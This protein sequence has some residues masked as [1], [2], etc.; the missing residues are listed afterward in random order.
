M[1]KIG[2]GY[3]SSSALNTDFEIIEEG[4]ERTLDRF[5]GPGNQMESELDMNSHRI[6]NLPAPQLPGDPVRVEDITDELIS[7]LGP[8]VLSQKANTD[9]GNISDPV[10]REKLL[11][12]D[13]VSPVWYGARG[14][15]I[16]ND[17]AP[18]QALE[19]LYSGR[20]VDLGGRTYLV[21]N[22][23]IGNTYVNGNFLISENNSRPDDRG[24]LLPSDDSPGMISGLTTTGG[25]GAPYSGGAN[26]T[27]TVPGRSTRNRRGILLSQ[28]SRADFNISGCF[29]SIYSWA[30]GN[31]SA[32]VAA[33]Q[34][35]AGAPQA[36]N[37]GS[38]EAQGYGFG[39]TNLCTAFSIA[40]GSRVGNLVTRNGRAAGT[41]SGNLFTESCQV[42][43]GK[44]ARLGNDSTGY[45]TVVG[46]VITDIPIAVAGSGYDPLVDTISIVDRSS[47]GSGASVSSFTV[48]G[49]G[50]ITGIAFTGGSGY[51]QNT[52]A[53]VVSP[54]ATSG[55][56][57]GTSNT[58]S[59]SA[60][61][62]AT[63]A[64]NGAHITGGNANTA[65]SATS[66][67][68]VS[69]AS[70]GVAL[71]AT[72]STVSGDGSVGIGIANSTVS[73]L[74]AVL[75]AS[76]RVQTS[77]DRSVSGGD[78]VS[79][80]ATT[81]NTKWRINSGNGNAQLAGTLTQSTPFADYGEYFEN[82]NHGTIPLGTVVAREG[83]K[84]R[85][86]VEGDRLAGVISAT[87]GIILGDSPFT[88]QGRYLYGDFGEPLMEE[89]EVVRWD[90]YDGLVSEAPT[91][92]P[93]DAVYSKEMV[94]VENPDYDP[95]LPNIPR[96]ER[97]DEW[98]LVGLLGQVFVRVKRDYEPDE[99]ITEGLR[100][101]EMK[102]K[103]DEEKG[104]GVAY[105]YLNA[106]A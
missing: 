53:Y 48:D 45:V 65:I 62:S 72:G 44:N 37:A 99:L 87:A 97:P 2:A 8:I 28:A 23:P 71:S 93:D 94:Q 68:T 24:K 92:I 89:V 80:A 36:F 75:L 31:V 19:S 47:A 101:M 76:R 30:Y 51:S 43:N 95:S 96:S 35:V 98:S 33:R 7:E 55:N 102:S 25:Y 14:D 10:W 6:I 100:V 91:P 60:T 12:S 16:V 67:T 82:L 21:D 34:S 57:A 77:L 85:P 63:L 64:S 29:V 54:V 46:G 13:N 69:S 9:A 3:R 5:G 49:T 61:N 42:G 86:W 90:D 50:A 4:F 26:N 105:C 104:Y 84:V 40:N 52:V 20:E 73:S 38:E 11:I 74:G 22:V 56:I 15:S 1:N 58:I 83:R 81:A 106:G 27:P 59:G 79:G 41:L 66:S 78:G 39:P 18:I 17:T 88:W 103:Y 32:N 70:R